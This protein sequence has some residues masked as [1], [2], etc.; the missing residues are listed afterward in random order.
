M[1]TQ[2]DNWPDDPYRAP[3]GIQHLIPIDA[4]SDIIGHCAHRV[5]IP[6][7]RANRTYG[8]GGTINYFS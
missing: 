8:E 1:V 3:C 6:H 5:D 4:I 2:G 7:T